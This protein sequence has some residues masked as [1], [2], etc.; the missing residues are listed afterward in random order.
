MFRKPSPD[1]ARRSSARADLLHALR[2]ALA[3]RRGSTSVWAM[4]WTAGMLMVGGLAIDA[5]NAYHT[6]A[7]LQATADGSAL[8]A[9][10]HLDDP[11]AA[12][13]AALA[14]AARNMPA[15]RHGAV[16]R[17]QD[18]RFGWIDPET[19]GFEAL[20]DAAFEEAG[21]GARAVEVAAGRVAARG[22][23]APTWLLRLA[24]IE[25]FDVAAVSVAGGRVETRVVPQQDPEWA[26]CTAGS[27]VSRS[28]IQFRSPIR[29]GPEFCVHAG[30]EFD[31][32]RGKVNCFEEGAKLSSPRMD[33]ALPPYA[34]TS[35]KQWENV[36]PEATPETLLV[37]REDAPT[38][39]LD[40]IEDG[41]F[42]R[43]WAD[44]LAHTDAQGRY[45]GGAEIPDFV[46]D[47]QGCAEVL[48]V[49]PVTK[50]IPP[51]A[52]KPHRIFLG[53]DEVQVHKK[54]PNDR[55]QD[56]AI[57]SRESILVQS[58]NGSWRDDVFLF[59]KLQVKLSAT[60]DWGDA[61]AVCEDR[62]YRV[63]ALSEW[64]VDVGGSINKRSYNG[65]LVAAPVFDS[66]ANMRNAVG[67]HVEA[68]DP[69]YFVGHLEAIG[70]PD[71]GALAAQW[72]LA[73]QDRLE[74]VVAGGSLLR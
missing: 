48:W 20:S 62:R 38:P 35:C 21:L 74:T 15:E 40:L 30:G 31:F 43:I 70:C 34:K 18:V 55:F 22:N 58:G 3:D 36:G 46:L 12:R 64:Q 27:I 29:I 33:P 66:A 47:A 5:S 2:R 45:C 68:A 73:A 9:A 26:A 11:E 24:G 10:L 4:F 7:R 32:S 25:G 61:D 50:E 39:V 23:A 16:I 17:G 19:G 14:L 56:I 44:V 37:R 49:D 6:K 71:G 53:V 69:M 60:Q 59:G 41:L 54:P 13:A 52:L 1:G 72:P 42:E 67:L 65:V 51:E 63:Y 8:A 28:S 57:L